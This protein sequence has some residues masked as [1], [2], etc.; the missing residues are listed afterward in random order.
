MLIIF[1][2]K[3]IVYNITL[4]IITLIVKTDT[5]RK[6]EIYY[7]MNHALDSLYESNNLLAS[8]EYDYKYNC[9]NKCNQY[10]NCT[11]VMINLAYC[12]IYFNIQYNYLVDSYNNL[13]YFNKK[14][15]FE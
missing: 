10:D 15:D 9:F 7:G 6:F 3:H 11:M 13:K 2:N 12:N 4:I 1:K 5:T 14:F 8:F